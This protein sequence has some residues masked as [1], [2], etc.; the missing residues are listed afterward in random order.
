MHDSGDT[1]GI[2]VPHSITLVCSRYEM[3]WQ[4]GRSPS[5]DRYLDV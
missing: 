1:T 4:A 2:K 3:E 5:I